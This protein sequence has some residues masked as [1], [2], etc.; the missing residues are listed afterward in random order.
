MMADEAREVVPNEAMIRTVIN[1]KRSSPGQYTWFVKKVLSHLYRTRYARVVETGQVRPS[2][3]I[4]TTDEA[5]A[6]VNM[7]GNL[8]RWTKEAE[9]MAAAR[10]RTLDADERNSLPKSE[11]T[12]GSSK[13]EGW[14]EEGI[15][16][17][18][19]LVV[20]VKADRESEAGKKFEEN[21]QKEAA[22][23]HLNNKR[24]RKAPKMRTIT[25]TND[26]DS[27]SESDDDTSVDT[28]A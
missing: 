14:N 4:S 18:N 17:F 21:F 19:E 22:A 26:L 13:S 27:D 11:Y 5:Y 8:K 12:N 20:E 15:N 9:M 16:R 24:K 23:N 28:G 10:G 3:L 25:A 2:D 6:L 1:D 7:E